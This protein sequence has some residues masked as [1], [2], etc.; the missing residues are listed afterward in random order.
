MGSDGQGPHLDMG[1]SRQGAIVEIDRMVLQ[2]DLL[3]PY[4]HGFSSLGFGEALLA[5][6]G[7]WTESTGVNIC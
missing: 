5:A 4:G 1:R 3:E 2:R 7:G 6:G